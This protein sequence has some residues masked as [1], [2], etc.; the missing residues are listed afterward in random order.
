[1]ELMGHADVKTTEID[2]HAMQENLAAVASP[3]D[4]LRNDDRA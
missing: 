4:T 2:T 3:L 1:M